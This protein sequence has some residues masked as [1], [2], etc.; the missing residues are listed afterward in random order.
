LT[1]A[2]GQINSLDSGDMAPNE[3]TKK[4][5]LSVCAQMSQVQTAWKNLL[6][7]DLPAFNAVLEK[8]KIKPLSAP[9]ATVSMMAKK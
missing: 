2:D 6:A 9:H 1:A 8:H 7:K 4:T 5:G 3:P